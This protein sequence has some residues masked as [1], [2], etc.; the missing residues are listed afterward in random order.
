MHCTFR[1]YFPLYYHI[2]SY[3]FNAACVTNANVIRNDL[4]CACVNVQIWECRSGSELWNDAERV[5]APWAFGTDSALLWRLLLLFPLCGALNLWHRLR[6]LCLIQGALPH[7]LAVLTESLYDHFLANIVF[8]SAPLQDL[9]TRHKMMCAEFL[10]N[11]Y[12]RVCFLAC[13]LIFFRC[14]YC[15]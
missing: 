12:D 1:V 2:P 5:P 13:L 14:S 3:Q 9:L 8:F 10:E 7:F 11:S 4:T 6:C 15:T